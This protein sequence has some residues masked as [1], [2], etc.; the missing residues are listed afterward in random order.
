MAGVPG[1]PVPSII[2]MPA[3]NGGDGAGIYNLSSAIWLSIDS[4]TLSNNVTGN[5]GTGGM[6]AVG[7]MVPP[8]PGSPGGLAGN[9]G[10]GGGLYNDGNPAIAINTTVSG[11]LTGNGGAGGTGGA[12]GGGCLFCY[13]HPEDT[14]RVRDALA[15]AGARVL[16]YHVEMDGLRIE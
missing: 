7:N 13:S 16:P 2:S 9:G 8:G 6:G 3:G 11:N 14:A 12:G 15:A 5:G 4:T 1:A 10:N